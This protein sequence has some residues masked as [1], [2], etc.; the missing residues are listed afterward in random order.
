MFKWSSVINFDLLWKQV[1]SCAMNMFLYITFAFVYINYC[2]MLNDY[3]LIIQN[4]SL[5][6]QILNNIKYVLFEEITK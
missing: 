5:I 3:L 1:F 2:N 4:I 6:F